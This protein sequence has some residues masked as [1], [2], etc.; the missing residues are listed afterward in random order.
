MATTALAPMN[1]TTAVPATTP[2]V[3]WRGELPALSGSM[4]TLRAPGQP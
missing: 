3:N 4:I 2:R 1:L